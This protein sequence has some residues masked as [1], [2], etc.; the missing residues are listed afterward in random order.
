MN[1]QDLRKSAKALEYL[2]CRVRIQVS[3]LETWDSG[4]EL[5]A[6]SNHD[7]M[8]RERMQQKFRDMEFLVHINTAQISWDSL[9]GRDS[10]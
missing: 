5:F 10:N 2:T 1:A 6:P 8:M 7:R 4:L 3:P 9:I